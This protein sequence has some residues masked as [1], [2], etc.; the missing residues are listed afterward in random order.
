MDD[1]S[2]LIV[3]LFPDRKESILQIFDEDE[4]FRSLCHDYA[5]AFKAVKYWRKSHEATA[6]KR[7]LEYESLTEDLSEDLRRYLGKRNI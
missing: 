7:V 2:Y 6:Q 3:N 1:V 5:D 4:E